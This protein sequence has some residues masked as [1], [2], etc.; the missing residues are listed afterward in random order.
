MLIAVPD[1]NLTTYDPKTTVFFRSAVPEGFAVIPQT[2]AAVVV[3]TPAI[4]TEPTTVT[5]TPA[6]VTTVTAPT[7]VT[8]TTI[9]ATPTIVTTP[10]IVAATAP[11]T[12]TTPTIVATTPTAVT[13]TVQNADGTYTVIEYPLKKEVTVTLSPVGLASSKAVATILRDDDGTRVILN[14]TDVPADVTAMNVYAVDDTGTITSLGP[15]VLANGTGKFSATTPLSKFMLIT[16][17]EDS[18]TVYDPTAKI[19][20]RSAVP[21]GFAVIPHT[22]NPVG[23]TVGA[24]STPGTTPASVSTVPMLNIPAYK[25]GDDTKLKLDFTG[26]MSGARANIF[27]EPHKNGKET[28][29]KMV[30]HELKDAPKGQAYILW[31]VSPDNQFFKLGQIIN[32]KERNEAEIKTTT[33]LNDFGLLVTM[34]DLAAL[35]TVVIPAGPRLGVIQITP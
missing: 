8:A 18:L 27:I 24:T 19:F 15:V 32:V 33:P 25:K 22:T 20:F 1:I 30:F 5:T 13:K 9:V 29:V 3:T 26:A 11:T 35:K 16:A 4:V 12:V 28:E 31:A 2:T 34:E 7:T 6:T 10:T 23:E 14:M 17:P 21:E